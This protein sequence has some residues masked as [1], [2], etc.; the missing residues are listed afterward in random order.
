[1]NVNVHFNTTRKEFLKTSLEK[2]VPG[3]SQSF[4]NLKVET[5]SLCEE[6]VLDR[7]KIDA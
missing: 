2:K 4:K 1:M 6:V 7:E 5:E 3:T